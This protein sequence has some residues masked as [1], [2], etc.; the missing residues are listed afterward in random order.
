M[1]SNIVTLRVSG[2]DELQKL[3]LKCRLVIPARCFRLY[4]ALL[5]RYQR[6]QVRNLAIALAVLRGQVENSAEF[7]LSVCVQPLSQSEP[8]TNSD[9]RGDSF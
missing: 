8:S 1:R 4:T 3:P 9:A 6:E 7:Q 5:Q 2:S